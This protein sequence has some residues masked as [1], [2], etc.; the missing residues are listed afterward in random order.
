MEELSIRQ[1]YILEIAIKEYINHASPISSKF[2]ENKYDLGV[3]PATIR[4]ELY[5]LVEKGYLYQPHTSSGRVPTDKGYRFFVDNLTEKEAAKLEM[6][7]IEE[8]KRMK[9]EIDGRV[10]FISEFTR[11]LANTSSSLTM[12]YFPRD[13]I[14]LK[15][16]WGKA[17]QDP[18]FDDVKKVHRF[19]TMVDD[20]EENVD[21]FFEDSK[22]QCLQVYI[23]KETPYFEN[24]DFSVVVSS[25]SI[26]KKKG[27]F[28][29]MGP[30]R[31]AYDKNIQLVE[32]IIDILKEK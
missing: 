29:I 18:E 4:G 16:G 1:K 10:H 6:K 26:N 14:L 20:F 24:I 25:C 21:N 2:I 19:T 22:E 17:L 11:F 13:H 23:G 32:S 5:D 3:S 7:M 28:A 31:M 15:E 9:R 12:S 30:K 27:Y 8:I